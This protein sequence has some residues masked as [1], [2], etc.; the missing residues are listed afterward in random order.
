MHKQQEGLPW[1]TW[2]LDGIGGGVSLAQLLEAVSKH[3]TQVPKADHTH[4]WLEWYPYGFMVYLD[5]GARCMVYLQPQ[6][7]ICYHPS[8]PWRFQTKIVIVSFNK[9]L[10]KKALL[11]HFLGQQRGYPRMISFLCPLPRFSPGPNILA[12]L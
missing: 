7:R 11:S 12:R 3:S 2:T 6:K 8:P 9:S 5:P 4:V 1:F 10:F